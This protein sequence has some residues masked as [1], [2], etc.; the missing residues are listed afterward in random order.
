MLTIGARAASATARRS[1][2]KA[3]S[4]AA[5]ARRLGASAL[6]STHLAAQLR[7]YC[8]ALKRIRG[9]DTAAPPDALA[10]TLWAAFFLCAEDDGKRDPVWKT[11]SG[12]TGW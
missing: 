1:R 10:R 6:H 4:T 11:R 3:V 7:T 12:G 5:P 2:R 9:G 8:G